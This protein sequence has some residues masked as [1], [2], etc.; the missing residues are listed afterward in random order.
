[1]SSRSVSSGARRSSAPRR[2]KGHSLVPEDARAY[3]ALAAS[4]LRYTRNCT[5]VCFERSPWNTKELPDVLGL[6]SSRRLIEIEIKVSKS[7]FLHDAEKPH[8]KTLLLRIMGK[9]T[10]A[11]QELWYLVPRWLAPVVLASGPEYAGVLVPS[12][13]VFDTFSGFPSLEILRPALRLHSYKLPISQ[14]FVMAKDMAGT[15]TSVLRDY[16][17]LMGDVIGAPLIQSPSTVHKADMVP[18]AKLMTTQL[19]QIQEAAVNK[20]PEFSPAV[21]QP[22]VSSNVSVRKTWTSIGRQSTG[23]LNTAPRKSR[24]S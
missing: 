9:M 2:G 3:R 12:D 18:H 11:P 14:V 17:K 1:M 13:A 19:V 24:E 23:Y 16:V 10:T 22:E 7:D 8:R 5:L 21:E 20:P 6:D 4:W 15:L